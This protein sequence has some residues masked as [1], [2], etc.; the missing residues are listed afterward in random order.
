MKLILTL[1][2]LLAWL[3]TTLEAADFSREKAGRIAV[4]FARILEQGHYRQTTIDD[5]ISK[6]FLKNYL[7]ALDPNHLIFVQTDV[8]AFI[9]KYETSLDDSIKAG[10]VSAGYDIFAIYLKRLE[11][12][13]QL[14]EELLKEPV[15]FKG[16]ESFNAQRKE[17]PW[18]KDD[19]QARVIWKQRV[20]FEL[21][22][23]R[24]AKLKDPEAKDLSLDP[25]SPEKLK[26]GTKSKEAQAAE[27]GVSKE[28]TSKPDAAVA[29]AKK[30]YD[31]SQT[32][33]LISKRYK[34]LLKAM[35]EFDS[36]EILQTYLTSLSHAYDPH[37]DYMGPTEASNFEINNVKL[38]LS[39]I[40]ALLRSED[41]LTKIVNVIPGGP[42]S[43]SK[44]L[45]ENDQIIAVAQGPDEPVDTIDMKLNKVVE[46]IRGPKGTQ[47]RLTI[48][49]ASSVDGSERKIISLVRD[50]IK[51]TESQAKS[52]V[53]DH[54][55][56][57]GKTVRIG[58]INLPTFYENCSKDVEKLAIRLKTEGVSGMVLDLRRN[59]GGLLPEAIKLAG[60]FVKNG[61]IVQVKNSDRR[62][63][64]YSDTNPGTAYTGPLVVLVS[65][66]SAS[67]SEIVAAALQDYGRAV[68]V[69]DQTTHGK[70]TVQTLLPLAPYMSMRN[71]SLTNAGKIKFTVSKF[72]RVAGG[73]TQRNGVTPDIILPSLFDHMELGEASLPNALPADYITPVPF[74]RLNQVAPFVGELR[75]KSGDRVLGATDF[76]YLREDIERYRKLRAEKVIS[77]NEELRRKEM[78][79]DK[80]RKEARKTERAARQSPANKVFELTLETVNKNKQLVPL[81]KFGAKDNDTIAS[82]DQA[83]VSETDGDLDSETS[84]KQPELDIHLD[85]ALNILRE[86]MQMI[87]KTQGK[88]QIEARVSF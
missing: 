27:D 62:S 81:N 23:D 70:G 67:A 78:R 76:S 74:N 63:E 34:R 12:K 61:P 46:M 85:E 28:K 72:Y 25:A 50:E 77:L 43:L 37:S 66:L 88:Q 33:T 75:K 73:T 64:I 5:A 51:L 47:V 6:Q 31:P 87:E 11:Q 39:G 17:E 18:P 80:G 53:I 56:S 57:S 26:Q 42:A 8:E 15:D 82:N 3:V 16:N 58:V 9:A 20:K 24:L 35:R 79:E 55:D 86:L 49:P 48:I 40:G 68:V 29:E 38:S 83:V 21:L 54:L 19:A 32:I 52:R 10:E 30:P 59:G 41:G 13:Q 60:L 45:H 2:T 36:E 84:E 4:T 65:H 44:Q 1:T 69:G 14:V 7:D 22:S 71:N